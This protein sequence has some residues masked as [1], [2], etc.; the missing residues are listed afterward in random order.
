MTYK[1]QTPARKAGVCFDF[2]AGEARR[3]GLVSAAIAAAAAVSAATAAETTASTTT[4][5]ASTKP[6]AT[7]T[8][9]AAETTASTAT[10]TG[11]LF[12]GASFIDGQCAAFMLLAVQSGDRSLGFLVAGHFHEPETLAAAGVSIIDNLSGHNLAMGTKQLFEFRAIHLVAQVPN[13]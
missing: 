8:T 4:T 11:T 13:I 7:S 10:T 2:N 12:T 5:A 9:T 3:S 6:T 1:T